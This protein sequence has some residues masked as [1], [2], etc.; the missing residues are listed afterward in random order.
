MGYLGH[1]K[2]PE[3]QQES[4][5]S[6]DTTVFRLYNIDNV[7]MNIQCSYDKHLVYKLFSCVTT[8]N[9]SICMET[10][11]HAYRKGLHSSV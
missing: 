3:T 10:V 4:D 6:D 9:F 1:E 7:I 8:I 11:N 2:Y 5:F